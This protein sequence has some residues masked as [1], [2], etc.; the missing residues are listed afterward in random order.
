M[1]RAVLVFRPAQRSAVICCRLLTCIKMAAVCV[2][3]LSGVK[4]GSCAEN[5]QSYKS[6][7][8]RDRWREQ[9][10]ERRRRQRQSGTYRCSGRCGP[11]CPTEETT[12]GSCTS[13]RSSSS[14]RSLSPEGKEEERSLLTEM[15]ETDHMT[16][17]HLILARHHC[18]SHPDRQ[19][20]ARSHSI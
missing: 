7:S 10:D 18:R 1:G 3:P 14:G 2:C 5:K 16:G 8:G 9:M 17:F 4:I 15:P 6:E 20:A 13:R 19:P 11:A 12:V